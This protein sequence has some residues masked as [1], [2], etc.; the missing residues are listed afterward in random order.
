MRFQGV[1]VS[2]LSST[3]MEAPAVFRPLPVLL[4]AL[5]AVPLSGCHDSEPVVLPRDLSPPAAPRGVYSVTGDGRVTLHWLD[6]TENDVAGYHVYQGPCASGPDCPYD[7]A[8]TTTGTSF[9]VAPLANGVTRFF[10]VSA[11][12]QAGNESDLS[13]ED[14]P[15]TPRPAGSGASLEDY[16]DRPATSGWDFSAFAVRPWDDARTDM[17]FSA[18]GSF[19]EMLVPDPASTG[20]QDMGFAPSLDAVDFAP[21]AGWSPSGGAELIVGHNY[22]VK[23]RD[24]HY[25]KFRVVGLGGRVVFDWAYQLDPGN[26]ELRLRPAAPMPAGVGVPPGPGRDPRPNL[27]TRPAREG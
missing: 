4:L 8:G 25:A 6:N 14:L 27:D 24:D 19:D 2:H 18:G 7:R 12:D 23:T 15:D 26:R 22:I 1:A 11:F 9:A 17:F 5:A 3:R 10:A 21:A 20:I 13:Y 16:R